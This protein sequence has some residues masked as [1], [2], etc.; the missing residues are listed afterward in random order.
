METIQNNTIID[1]IEEEKTQTSEDG[2]VSRV[3]LDAASIATKF[4]QCIRQLD[5]SSKFALRITTSA[6][7]ASLFILVPAPEHQFPE[8]VW[9]LITAVVVSWQASP[10]IASVS[11]KMIERLLGTVMGACVGLLLGG[12]SLLFLEHGSRGHSLYLLACLLVGTFL[13]AYSACNTGQRGHYSAVL[14]C[15]TFGI[16]LLSFYEDTDY[17]GDLWRTGVFRMLNICIG[18]LLAGLSSLCV[19]PLSTKTLIEQKVT[20]LITETGK[21]SHAVLVAAALPPPPLHALARKEEKEDE[22][23]KLY[24]KCLEGWKN[25]RQLFSLL[26]YDPIFAQLSDDKKKVF[27][28]TWRLRLGRVLR[29]QATLVMLDG[30]NRSRLHSVQEHDLMARVGER[31]RK[32]Y[33]ES[34]D[35][36]KKEE[37]A[38]SLIHEDIPAVRNLQSQLRRKM[39]GL[40]PEGVNNSLRIDAEETEG[41]ILEG[42]DLSLALGVFDDIEFA[43]IKSKIFH[44]GQSSL[45][46]YQLLEFLIFRVVRLE[47]FCHRTDAELANQGI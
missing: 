15:A 3:L 39:S 26:P 23:H 5:E 14:G 34:L 27:W 24:M 30:L 13:C 47:R 20:E 32:L 37:I 11:K 43:P 1:D 7:L 46:F 6:F 33:E 19:F 17:T 10:D 12:V 25:T 4:K 45:F 22:S 41:L 29:I 31:I 8:G 40:H 21:T 16:I 35:S 2:S 9:I 42:Y 36:G 44:P 18:G 38:D 28:E